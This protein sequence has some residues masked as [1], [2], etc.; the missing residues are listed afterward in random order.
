MERV[1]DRSDSRAAANEQLAAVAAELADAIDATLPAWV[2][3]SVERIVTA[4][5]GS[6]SDEAHVAALEAGQ[7]AQEELG[8][9]IRALLETDI[10]EQRGNPLALIRGAVVYPTSVLRGLGIP[11]VERDR[12]AERLFPD[13]LYDLTPASFAELHPSVHE[14]GIAWGA[15]KA[16][17]H[18]RRRRAEGRR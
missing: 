14:P 7:R 13:D 2:V 3:A 1:S 5:R 8:P 4:Y 18:L 6:V 17:V 12:E 16:H 15:A 11:P 9:R 10:D